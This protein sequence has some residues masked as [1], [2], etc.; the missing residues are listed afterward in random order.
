MQTNITT[1]G[2]LIVFVALIIFWVSIGIYALK[3]E[4]KSKS[5]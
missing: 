1:T 3:N 2:Q 4:I 5:H